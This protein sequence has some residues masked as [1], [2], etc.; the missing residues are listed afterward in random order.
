[1]IV[2]ADEDGLLRYDLIGT[3]EFFGY[4]TAIM[5]R[6]LIWPNEKINK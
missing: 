5:L 3:R 6:P 4:S 2:L 1:M